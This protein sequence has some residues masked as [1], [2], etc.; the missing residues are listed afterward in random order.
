MDQ[1]D[2]QAAGKADEQ[3]LD[4]QTAVRSAVVDILV[5]ISSDRSTDETVAAIRSKIEEA[6]AIARAARSDTRLREVQA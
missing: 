5:Y 4:D 1:P 2:D 6:A 3:Q